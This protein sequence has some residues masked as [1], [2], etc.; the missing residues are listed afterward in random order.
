MSQ[1]LVRQIDSQIVR[2]L[3][4]RARAH[5]VSAE[6]AHR[7]ILQEALNRPAMEKPSLIAFL[8]SHE[9]ASDVEFNLGR[10]RELEDRE[11]GL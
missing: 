6:E 3:K 4:A 5:G 7:Q 2:K 11:I 9:V 1:L 8:M 10:S